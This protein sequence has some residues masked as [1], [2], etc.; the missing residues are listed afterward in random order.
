MIDYADK[1]NQ[2]EPLHGMFTA[3]PRHY[4]LVN[5]I[6]TWGF[7]KRWRLMAAKECLTSQPQKVLDLCCGTGDLAINIARLAFVGYPATRSFWGLSVL[8]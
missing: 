1:V 6:I 7:D 3:I 5:R 2:I 8:M 4:D